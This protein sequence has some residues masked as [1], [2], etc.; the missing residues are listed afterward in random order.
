[1]EE[2]RE[3]ESSYEREGFFNEWIMRIQV[4]RMRGGSLDKEGSAHR[5][6]DPPVATRCD[7]RSSFDDVRMMTWQKLDQRCENR[8]RLRGRFIAV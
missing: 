1:M 7:Q 8:S 5:Q 2:P 4:E 3:E 6:K